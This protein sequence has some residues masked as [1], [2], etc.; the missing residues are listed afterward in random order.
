[1]LEV[2]TGSVGDEQRAEQEASVQ[3]GRSAGAWRARQCGGQR[4]REDELA[5]RQVPGALQH[6][7][8]DLQAVPE[9]DHDQ[10]DERQIRRRSPSGAEVE[11]FEAAVAQH[12]AREHEQ[13][14]QREKLRR[15]RPDRS[16]PRM[17]SA[18]KT[19]PRR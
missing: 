6:L 16:A 3:S 17:S 8:L 13:R 14:G 18:P 10:R 5:Q 15:A 7:A 2:S 11:H 4:H 9:E 1:M 19:A 12:E